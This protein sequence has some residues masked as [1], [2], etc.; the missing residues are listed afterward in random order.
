MNSELDLSVVVPA[1]NEER[2]LPPT[3]LDMLAVL[4]DLSLKFEIIVV[5]DGSSDGTPEVVERAKRLHRGTRLIKFPKN[6]GKGAAVR[7]GMLAAQGRRRLFADADGSTPFEEIKRL[8]S[9]LDNGAD[10]AIG[11][12]ALFGPDTQV[13]TRWHR[14]FLGRIFN[15]CVNRILLPDIADTQCGF[16]LFTAEAADFL[17]ARQT[18][19]GFSFDVEL[20]FLA[21]RVGMR[22]VEVPINWVNVPGSKV[23]LAV[24]SL[25]MLRD[26]TR[27][28]L[29]H[30]AASPADF[31]RK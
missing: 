18:S 28:R 19:D 1:F 26:V 24:D 13:R 16:K 6:R 15:N 3:L 21:R 29:I 20:L 22:M 4:Y 11:S 5:D 10:V 17:F 27:F 12:R 2:R 30:R 23:N 31:R 7:A 9:A 14:K 8:L 25:K